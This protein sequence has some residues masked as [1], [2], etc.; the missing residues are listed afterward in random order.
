MTEADIKQKALQIRQIYL[1]WQDQQTLLKAE[2]DLIIQNLI[3][4]LENYK[5]EDIKKIIASQ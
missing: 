4:D 1:D 2:Q 3:K 5:I